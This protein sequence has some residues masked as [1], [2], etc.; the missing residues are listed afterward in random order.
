[1]CRSA[2]IDCQILCKSDDC[3]R[4]F[5]DIKKSPQALKSDEEVR[6]TI[7]NLIHI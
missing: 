2:G 5:T 7:I 1:M 4:R 6:M 3:D